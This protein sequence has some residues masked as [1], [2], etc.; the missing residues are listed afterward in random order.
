MQ[1]KAAINYC[2]TNYVSFSIISIVEKI[3]SSPLEDTSPI[4]SELVKFYTGESINSRQLYLFS[5]TPIYP[6]KLAGDFHIVD[7]GH[8][9]KFFPGMKTF[10]SDQKMIKP[11]FA[12]FPKTPKFEPNP[13]MKTLKMHLEMTE[14]PIHP[15]KLAGDFHIVDRGHVD[16]NFPGM[17]R[18]LAEIAKSRVCKS[19]VLSSQDMVKHT[20]PKPSIE[21]SQLIK[22]FHIENHNKLGNKPFSGMKTF[23]SY[24]GSARS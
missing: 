6:S 7:H 3:K 8:V 21:T 11:Y 15:I 18:H 16:K 4:K 13:E 14:T 12:N 10:L 5:K 19:L 24:Q 17:E 9:D 22:G 20:G 2:S 1:N 23:I